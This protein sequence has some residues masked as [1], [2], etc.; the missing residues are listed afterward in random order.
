MAK[1][2]S[3]VRPLARKVYQSMR[4][5]QPADHGISLSTEDLDNPSASFK[6]AVIERIK[7]LL[8]ARTAFKALSQ[9]ELATYFQMPMQW[10]GIKTPGPKARELR[11]AEGLTLEGTYHG[12][13]AHWAFVNCDLTKARFMNCNMTSCVFHN[14]KQ[15]D[16]SDPT[17]QVDFHG[18]LTNM[19]NV[20]GLDD[21]V[22][23]KLVDRASERYAYHPPGTPMN[24]IGWR[25]N[26]ARVSNL[27]HTW[28]EK[29]PDPTWAGNGVSVGQVKKLRL[30][31][32][33]GKI[34]RKMSDYCRDEEASG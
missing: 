23:E 25:R 21:A 12:N 28:L 34:S 6:A 7:K 4:G 31:K 17:V 10:H 20:V 32:V 26:S 5:V 1:I 15:V 27:G 29:E 19:S 3:T 22:Y 33:G 8:K 11:Y 18:R 9:S 13:F 14:C 16:S 30:K 24:R 2:P